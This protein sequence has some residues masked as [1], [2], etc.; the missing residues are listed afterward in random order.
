VIR[1]AVACLL[2]CLTL[3]APS[4][5][6]AKRVGLIRVFLTT[7]TSLVDGRQHLVIKEVTDKRGHRLGSVAQVCTDVTGDRQECIGTLEMPLGRIT[8][9]GSRRS[10]RY[11]VF[12]VTGGTGIYAGATGTYASSTIALDPRVEYL[13]VSLVP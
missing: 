11:Y 5:A 6:G 1:A 4:G 7:R 10:A 13:L 3:A 12:A 9:Q 8:Y 2:A